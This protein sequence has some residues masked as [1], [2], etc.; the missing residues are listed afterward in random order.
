[1]IHSFLT[2]IFSLLFILS[3]CFKAFSQSPVQVIPSVLP[4][5]STLLSE[6]YSGDQARLSVTLLNTDAAEPFLQGYL[7]ITIEGQGVKL[8]SVPFGN[9]PIID[10]MTG[11]P[12]T[13]SQ[14]D[15]APYFTP[16]HLQG[17]GA[18][19]QNRLPEGFYQF[20]F[21]VLE[22]NTGRLIGAKQCAQAYLTL[23]DPAF[24]ILPEKGKV[25]SYTNPFN[26]LFQWMPRHINLI[27]T[28]Y[29]FTLV[30]IWD[31]GI[32]PEAAFY[33]GKPIYTA[34]TNT[35][36]LYYGPG[37]PQL[38]MGKKYAWRVK[39]KV[40][41][42]NNEQEPFKNEGYSE[43]FWFK[44]QG[45]CLPLQRATVIADPRTNKTT[46]SWITDPT[47]IGSTKVDYRKKGTSNWKTL[48]APSNQVTLTGLAW[49]TDYEYQLGNRCVI[50]DDFAYGNVQSFKTLSQDT[51]N[52]MPG[53][54]QPLSNQ[55][56]LA[57]LR[58]GDTI[59]ASDFTMVLAKVSGANG[60]F[61]GEGYLGLIVPTTTTLVAV[62]ASFNNISVNTD[63]QVFAGRIVSQYD[64]TESNVGNLDPI[65]QGGAG[66]G[67]VQ[68][69]N[70]TAIH[71][72]GT[73]DPTG[74][75]VIET[76]ITGPGDTT[77]TVT[78]KSV[79]GAPIQVTTKKLPVV[80]QDSKGKIYGIDKDGKITP[81]G[82]ASG[83][84][85]AG[86][87][88]TELNKLSLDQGTV[89]FKTHADQV[90]ALDLYQDTY[91]KSSLFDQEYEK[92]NGGAYRVGNK[93]LVTNSTD[94]IYA[95]ISGMGSDMDEDSIRFITAKGVEFAATKKGLTYEVNLLSGPANDAQELYAI[96]SDY[97]KIKVDPANKAKYTYSLG[98]LKIATYEPKQY[99]VNVVPVGSAR[100]DANAIASNLNKVYNP[101]GVT[102]NVIPAPGIDYGWDNGDGKLDLTGA[103]KNNKYSDEMQKLNVYYITNKRVDEKT[104]YLFVFDQEPAGGKANVEGDML[105]NRQ[106]GYLFP[107][108]KKNVAAHELGHGFF[109]LEHTFADAYYLSANDLPQNLMNYNDGT[110]LAKLQWDAVHAPGMVFGIFESEGDA[111]SAIL[112]ISQLASFANP[113]KTFTFIAP[114]GKLITV[115]SNVQSVKFSTGDQWEQSKF[116]IP[117]GALMNFT[118]PEGLFS[119]NGDPTSLTFNNYSS[120]T[121]IYYDTYSAKQTI[122]T[123]KPIVG[124]PCFDEGTHQFRVFKIDYSNLGFDSDRKAE[125]YAGS[126]KY[127]DFDFLMDK[128]N[129]TQNGYVKFNKELGVSK[130]VLANMSAF[131]P[132]AQSF[133]EAHSAEAN[134]SADGSSYFVYI[135]AEQIN[136]YPIVWDLCATQFLLDNPAYLVSPDITSYDKIQYQTVVTI[137]DNTTV[138]GFQQTIDAGHRI[139]ITPPDYKK[140]GED[141]GAL[142]NELS[143]AYSIEQITAVLEKLDKY[144]CVLN[145]LT[146]DARLD[147]LDKIIAAGDDS[148]ILAWVKNTPPLYRKNVA[149]YF[150]SHPNVLGAAWNNLTGSDLDEFINLITN[151]YM[152]SNNIDKAQYKNI[153]PPDI[154]T[155]DNNTNYFVLNDFGI[156]NL[157]QY[158]DQSLSMQ[159]QSGFRNGIFINANTTI[160]S[161]EP[162]KVASRQFAGGYFDLVI[163]EAGVGFE[164][165]SEDFKKGDRIVV[166]AIYAHW[167]IHRYNL[168]KSFNKVTIALETISLL[169][170]LGESSVVVATIEAAI[171]TTNL[172][173]TI[174]QR[175]LAQN[176][177][178]AAFMEV[179]NVFDNIYSGVGVLKLI[180]STK[181]FSL[182]FDN[183]KTK[184]SS[185]S[186]VDRKAFALKLNDLASKIA[187]LSVLA[188][189]TSQ[190]AILGSKKVIEVATTMLINDVAN[191]T[192]S[193]YRSVTQY[194]G[195]QVKA[196][197]VSS[198]VYYE[199]AN[200]TLKT[201]GNILL[202]QIHWPTTTSVTKIG[203][204]SNV[205]YVNQVGVQVIGDLDIVKVADNTVFLR[206]A[207]NVISDAPFK[208]IT[209]DVR[210]A[211]NNRIIHI[212]KIVFES[213]GAGYKF[214]GCHSKSALDELGANARIE[215]TIPVNAEGVYEAKVFAK[216]PNGIEI[217]KSGNQGKST[218]FPDSWDE[219]RILEETEF[220]VKNNKGL[221]DP[222][223]DSKGFWG[224]AKNGKTKIGFYYRDTDG[225]IGSFFPILP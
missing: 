25:I 204:Y 225:Y 2:R 144:Q 196:V 195:T 61:S 186:S 221:I 49:S 66:V 203:T 26:L 184:Y 120:G 216:G 39:T 219:A 75:A 161:T 63:H 175:E 210:T 153:P 71:V 147:F 166:P 74:T 133:L 187:K 6:Y 183:I 123:L 215:I 190:N 209:T 111:E 67:N 113:D 194:V 40:T 167:L 53:P 208:V 70:T 59:Y 24:L 108:S 57:A 76:T 222:L 91:G 119:I 102:W 44:L 223:D 217:P 43:I 98:K 155:A 28:E 114:S 7:R 121:K 151:W 33:T 154:I 199:V 48:E 180:G 58:A 178:C 129:L 200:A 80:V 125:K 10:L 218:F 140:M 34:T 99:T 8:Q 18:G 84:L 211:L 64:A 224:Y 17:T 47:N 54:A 158:G 68:T 96:Y 82:Q 202:D 157:Y 162:T 139:S 88:A 62:R 206:V 29:E 163:L 90:Y 168:D 192:T 97:E 179:W 141:I 21:E 50:T 145:A 45:E 160:Y 117:A 127:A 156:K 37:E 159:Y 205:T 30:E 20:C 11:A 185:L 189:N 16:Q 31:E 182:V 4:P 78:V 79:D 72:S 109:H 138:G 207:N 181:Q 126:G 3:F 105:R 38:L 32:A 213:K 118:T 27:N 116:I 103:G 164:N 201:D 92:L 89:T 13:V 188:A 142:Q 197:V 73:I 173:L 220:A 136:Q 101:I 1:M 87:G 214:S 52:C 15:F 19:N 150:V 35:S 193:S 170:T 177:D 65:T 152:E 146:I 122:E 93:L 110:D 135:H 55:E 148:H 212:R 9:Y 149:D 95:T 83:A 165:Y 77:Y 132:Q 172:V 115:P 100:V 198:A 36:N 112:A 171:S 128:S 5:Y 42:G 169:A 51:S 124:V 60:N 131:K 56:P 41:T 86:K 174:N 69:G 106:F 134:C 191:F 12:V 14:S 85:L 46:L 176:A 23:S 94:K 81:L 137:P 104:P 107:S 22:K 143:N 130:Y